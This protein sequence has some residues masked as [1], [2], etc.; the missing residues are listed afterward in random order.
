MI[1]KAIFPVKLMFSKKATKINEIFTVDL[2]IFSKGLFTNYV[3]KIVAFL[4][5][6]PPCVDIFY[7]MNIDKNGYWTTYLPRLVNVVCEQPLSQS[8]FSKKFDS[9]QI[10]MPPWHLYDAKWPISKGGKEVCR[11]YCHSPHFL[12]LILLMWRPNYISISNP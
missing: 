8:A 10:Y 6:L 11:E 5:H 9:R 7:G 1:C 4:D 3:D 12:N 2:T